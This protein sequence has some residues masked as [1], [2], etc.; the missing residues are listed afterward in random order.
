[1][2][3]SS[4]YKPLVRGLAAVAA[5]GLIAAGL[6]ACS[7]GGSGSGDGGSATAGDVTW[8]GWTPELSVAPQYIEKFNEEYPDIKVT[9]QQIPIDGWEAKL[10][11][12]L[13]SNTGPDVFGLAPG[14]MFEQFNQFATD[15][16]PGVEK[17]LGSDW[18]TKIS[19][20]GVNGLSND[21]GQLKAL[22]VGSTFGGPV[23]INQDIFDKYGLTPPTD[24]DQWA[25]V[26]ATLDAAGQQC[27]TQGVAQV[28][29]DQDTLQAISDTIN[30]GLYTK[31]TQGD[32]KW[33]DPD[34]VAAFA[35]WKSMFDDGIMQPGALGVQQ[36]PD[37][38]NEFMSQKA[39][40]VM[41]GT[42][43]MQYTRVAG[44]TPAIQAAGVGDPVPFTA[45][46]IP[47]P[48]AVKG[49]TPGALFGDA[50][51]GLAVNA[52]SKNRNAATTF[53][54]WMGTS[55]AGQQVV[56][57]ALNDIPSLTGVEPDWSQIELVNQDVQQ[58][59]LQD[60]M[61]Q[62]ADVTENRLLANADLATAI[63]V[64]ATTV[65]SGD[66]TPEEATKTLQSAA[67]A[68]GVEFK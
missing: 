51:Y 2:R 44:M 9:Y 18:N 7:S 42:W 20:L 52:K 12:A 55:A 38:N 66:A 53:A 32:A 21:D 19:Q 30:P 37:A 3:K 25:K 45:V 10:R 16:T 27:F 41:M 23:W 34:L 11:P 47:F 64:A 4:A 26:C 65:A 68:A 14:A 56:A 58:P 43:Y 63:G 33:T 67:E 57:N 40:M 6:G 48:S 5:A 50:D 60:L 28:A 62:T 22:S 39:A 15:L 46:P 49:G 29:F 13:S 17:A 35:A 59:A 54:V 36:Y 24:F 1:M 31:A 61:K 8:W